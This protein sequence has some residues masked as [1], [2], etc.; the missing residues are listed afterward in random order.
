MFYTIK[1]W[2]VALLI[3][4]LFSAVLISTSC[5]AQ[6]TDSDT[7]QFTLQQAEK[8][9]ID[10]NFLLLAGHYNVDA[11]K[12][13][14][15]QAKVWQNPTINTDFMIGADGK[16]FQYGKDANGNYFGQYYV[17]I[18]QLI[19]TARKRGKQIDLATTNSQIAELQLQD[20]LRNLRYQLHQD[21]FAL[22]QQF[23][24]LKVYN[25]HSLQLD[26]L[27]KAM[28][29][30]LNAGNIAQKDFVRIQALVISLQQDLME[31]NKNILDTENDFK[32][33]L[34]I[35]DAKVFVT[36]AE[37]LSADNIKLPETL[38]SLTNTALQTNPYYLLQQKQITFQQQNVTYQKALRSPDITLGP[39][40]DRNSNF[41]PNY[42]G[43]GIS[44]P[45]PLL[46]RNTGNI[47]SAELN[48]KQQTAVTQNAETELR[49]N[50][51]NAYKKLLLSIQQ[52]SA[53][54]KSFYTSYTNIFNNMLQSY[55]QKQ[56]SLLEFLD[57]FNDYT[58]SQE[59]LLQQ[60][61]N[62]QLSNEELQYHIGK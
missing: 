56:I 49:N 62:L 39:N 38:E 45:I 21:Y 55:Q 36:P 8:Q 37:E 57:F 24:L 30:Q 35:K 6:K 22:Q 31:L 58:S 44:M 52:N 20:I 43:L 11:Q 23:A 10:S 14:V 12:A 53:T 61:L 26:K 33:L 1:R 25:N 18:Q 5:V 50:V 59:K 16:Y 29:A 27:S 4:A 54:E 2:R 7:L 60:Q 3:T 41:A 48:V 28:E 51:S 17:Q 34:Q 42:V 46:N 32:T 19:Y 40:F 15:E 47:K 13:L 9:F